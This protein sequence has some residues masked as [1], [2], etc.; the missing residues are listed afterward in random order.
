MEIDLKK[1]DSSDIYIFEID[2]ISICIRK[3]SYVEN[4][5]NFIT[6]YIGTIVNNKT[7]HYYSTYLKYDKILPLIDT[8]KLIAKVS[9]D[10]NFLNKPIYLNLKK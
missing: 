2:S 5:N 8:I 9:A 7:K 1:I 6:G 10:I 4:R 3:Y